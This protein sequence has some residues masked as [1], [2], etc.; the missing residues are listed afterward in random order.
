MHDVPD[1]VVG[2]AGHH[3]AEHL[4]ALTLPLGGGILLAHRPKMNALAQQIHLPKVLTPALIDDAQHH[5]TLDLTQ[6]GLAK[7]TLAGLI[8]RQRFVV[9]HVV[10]FLR[11]RGSLEGSELDLGRPQGFG[12]R[13]QRLKIPLL[14]NVGHAVGSNRSA[15]G[16]VEVLERFVA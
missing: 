1:E 11:A 8:E 12:L 10:E 9:E 13:E 16:V 5:L 7:L 4:E 6:H 14:D 2:D 15:D 3:H